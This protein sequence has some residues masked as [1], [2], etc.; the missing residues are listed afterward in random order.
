MEIEAKI[1]VPDL[2]PLRARLHSLAA[3]PH[4]Q[5]RERNLVL[6]DSAGTLRSTGKLLRIRSTGGDDC[7]LT[8][9]APAQSGE[10]K[11]REEIETRV[12]SRENL[13]RQLSFLGYETAWIYEKDRDSWSYA[14]CDIAL[15]TLPEIGCFIEIEGSPEAIHRVC[16]DLGLDPKR[17]ID[18]NYLGLWQKHLAAQGDAQRDMIFP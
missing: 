7:I 1:Q 17:H 11:T 2:A 13:L 8:V 10:F 18:D 16:A 12:A 4:G 15:D 3:T 9:K 14:G 5:V 6:D